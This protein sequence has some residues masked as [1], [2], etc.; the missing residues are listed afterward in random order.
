MRTWTPVCLIWLVSLTGGCTT[1]YRVKLDSVAKPD[2]NAISY[3]L[4]NI[5]SLETDDSLRSREVSSMVRT[6]LSGRGLYEAPAK[7][8]A[9]MIVNIEYGMK[10]VVRRETRWKLPASS[11][12]A[13][14]GRIT[15]TNP[16]GFLEVPE[17]PVWEQV[18]VEVLTYEKYVHLTA[19]ENIPITKGMAPVEV[20]SVDVTSEGKSRNLR[21]YL[22]VLIAATI[23]YMGRDSHGQKSIRIKDT[24]ADLVFVKQ[25]M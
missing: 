1:S 17:A 2:A 20:W 19:R 12:S 18:Q 7:V 16:D 21:Q 25:G 14:N 22:P 10:P 9:D 3:S 11:K 4:R 13:N 8:V 23:E 24:D 6:A 15:R 5:S